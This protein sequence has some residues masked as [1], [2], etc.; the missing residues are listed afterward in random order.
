MAHSILESLS[1]LARMV[2]MA[3]FLA[4]IY[5]IILTLIKHFNRK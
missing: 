4:L 2:V 3:T 5:W 1:M